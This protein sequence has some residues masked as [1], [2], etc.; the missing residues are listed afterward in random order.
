MGRKN[1]ALVAEV[2]RFS[3]MAVQRYLPFGARHQVKNPIDHSKALPLT[4]G[5]QVNE[6]ANTRSFSF[7]GFHIRRDALGAGAVQKLKLSN[8]AGILYL[9]APGRLWLARV[10]VWARDGRCR[11]W[12]CRRFE[13]PRY[14]SNDDAMRASGTDVRAEVAKLADAPDLGS[15]GAIHRGSSP[16]FRTNPLRAVRLSS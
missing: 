11:H 10:R 15:G 8:H 1:P 3:R 7:V 12:F 4:L 9:G 13:G 6:V 5:I 14:N 2:S 16:L